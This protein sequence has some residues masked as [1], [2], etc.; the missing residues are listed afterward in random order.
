MF[1]A[2]RQWWSKGRGKI[3]VRL[4]IFEFVVV[5]AGVLAAQLLANWASNR[6]ALAE[7]DSAR[8]RARTQ[9][10]ADLAYAAQWRA[11]IPCLDQRMVTVMRQA[12]DGSLA[13]EMI[14][15]PRLST[16]VPVELGEQAEL[17]LRRRDGDAEA[18]HLAEAAGDIDHAA[19]DI[20]T[21]VR[22]WGRLGLADS[23]LGL[24]STEDRGAA[25]SAAA[26]IRSS[27]RGLDFGLADLAEQA[28]AI[29][30]LASTQ[31]PTRP[32]TTCAEIW[33]AG[34][35]SISR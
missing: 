31:L 3:T 25:R 22:S 5:M 21:I 8:S 11:A 28:A 6:A 12:A 7:M 34:A 13:S 16:F 20:G 10:S 23:S 33:R 26:D 4:F 29:G 15:R 17:L 9:L 14:R 30:V 24:V 1:K 19:L 32:A 27:L 2:V 18:D 35:I